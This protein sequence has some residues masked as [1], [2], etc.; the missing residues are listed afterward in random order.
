MGSGA[1]RLMGL[2]L[3]AMMVASVAC[4][5]SSPAPGVTSSPT[6]SGS[7][8]APPSGTT[9]GLA[10]GITAFG[11]DLYGVVHSDG[12]NIVYSPFSIALAMSMARVGAGGQTASEIDRVM[13]YPPS[14][15]DDLFDAIVRGAITT[16]KAPPAASPRPTHTGGP[17]APPVVAI[18]NGLFVEKGQEIGSDFKQTLKSKYQAAPQSLDFTDPVAADT[19][20]GWVAEHTADRIKKL[21]GSLDAATRLVLVN[22]VYMKAEW[23]LPFVREPIKTQP[24]TRADGSTVMVPTMRQ[25]FEALKY[26]AGPNWQAVELP[27]SPGTLAMWVLVPTLGV[28]PQAVLTPAVLR[29]TAAGFKDSFV[30]LSMPK[31][32]F[33]FDIDLVEKLRALGLEAP[34]AG[35]ADFSGIAS[36]LYIGQGV[37][38]ANISVDE[39][40]TEAAAATGFAFVTSA[41]GGKPKSVRADHPFA[42][43]IVDTRTKTPLFMGSVGDPS[44]AS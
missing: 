21:F 25:Q 31:W 14:G 39:Y 24:F 23:Q 19:I 10:L 12:P 41:P 34:F 32:D 18:A 20:N 43:V 38:R 13:H 28:G 40:G 27:Y 2:P 35:D 5:Q 26:T 8:S 3:A 16:D 6:R 44:A 37:H 9:A 1:T 4:G 33:G 7:T 17:S 36:G 29:T 15:R 30:D 42:F 22:A 11:C